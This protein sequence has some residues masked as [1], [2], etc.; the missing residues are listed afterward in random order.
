M[1]KI[2]RSLDKFVDPY[3]ADGGCD[4]GPG[5]WG[6]AG[7]SLFDCL[8][9]LHSA[10]GGRIDVYDRPLIADMG[11]FIYRAHAA[12]PYFVNFADAS[13]LVS[14]NASL[15]YRYGERIGDADMAA[16][17][18]HLAGGQNLAERGVGDSICRQLPA[19]FALEGL[20]AHE[21]SEPLLRDVWLPAIQVMAARDHGGSGDGFFVAAKGGHNEESHNHNDVGSFVVYLDGEPV[22]VDAGVEGY[23]AKTFSARRYEIWTMQSA[24]H[25]LPTVGEVMQRVGREF[26]AADVAHRAD[27][28]AASLCMDIAEAYPAEAGLASWRRT[29]IL[30][31]GEEVVVE[32]EYALERDAPHI[33]WS[34]L[35]ACQVE[36]G[37][38]GSGEARLRSVDL[39]G[40]RSSGAARLSF[41]PEAAVTVEEVPLEDP[42]VRR[43]WG[44]RLWRILLRVDAPARQGQFVLRIGRPA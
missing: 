24:Y 23:T 18:A 31:R 37:P 19:L 21:P 20:L 33:T 15:V 13:A 14:P 30:R 4:E 26:A 29:V 11:R 28:S 17:G 40:G 5:Y 36:V 22:L 9:L 27:T 16:F 42:G 12:G 1:G 32:D 10:S 8:E 6:R 25:N 3:P 44:E 7:A 2:L 35:S 39:G 43:V 38:R 41:A 34:L